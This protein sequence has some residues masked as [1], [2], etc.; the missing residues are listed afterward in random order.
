MSPCRKMQIDPYLSSCKNLKFNW[1]KNL[2]IKPDTLNPIDEK[3]GKS[4][5]CIGTGDNFFNRV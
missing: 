5:E 4:L 1:I 3:L 2:N